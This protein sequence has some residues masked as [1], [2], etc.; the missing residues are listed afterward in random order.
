MRVFL[1]LDYELFMGVSGT[2]Y[3]CLIEP[4]RYLQAVIKEKDIKLTLFVDAAYLL[5][6]K[7]LMSDGDVLAKDYQDVTNH[8]NELQRM[9]H[10]IQLHIHPQWLYSIFD[11]HAWHM[12]KE[13]Y[14][15]SD[16]SNEQQRELISKCCKLLYDITGERV[17]A[18]RA[19]GYSIPDSFEDLKINGVN[20]DSSAQPGLY[21][22]SRYQN[23]DYRDCPSKSEWRF[24]NNPNEEVEEGFFIEYPISIV[25][26]GLFHYIYRR[27]K[28]K[29]AHTK[30]GK[31]AWGDGMS[32]NEDNTTASVMDKLKRL[33]GHRYVVAS[34]DKI[35]AESLENVYKQQKKKGANTFVII[36]H[37]KN[38]TPY[39]IGKLTT[40][41]T[42]HP[43]VQWDVMR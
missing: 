28:Y 17:S 13:H 10:R 2:P 32:I 26:E 8:I 5:R 39:S 22:N 6:L 7:E 14:K 42:E 37:P 11:G 4:M 3:K 40:F 21:C 31:N 33:V 29:Y 16:L 9:G 19:G 36:G 15:L 43:E 34:I 1:T 30:L 41:I 35:D 23:Y 18:F 12:D 38:L 25:K 27:L 20:I 24:E